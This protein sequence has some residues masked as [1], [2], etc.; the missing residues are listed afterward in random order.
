[1][2]NVSRARFP[3]R[4]WSLVEGEFM[5]F[6]YLIEPPFNYVDGTGRITGCDVELARYVFQHIGIDEVEFVETT[7]AQLLPGLAQGRWQM[8]TGLFASDERRQSAL[9]SDPIWALPDGLLV[10]RADVDRINGYRVVAKTDGLKIAVI[11]DQL[12]HQTALKHGIRANGIVVFETYAEAAGAVRDGRVDAYAS[13][14]Q[15]HDGF[16]R[17]TATSDLALVKI[18]TDEK[19]PALGCFA[20]ARTN[21]ELKNR[22]DAVLA[23]FIGGSG[24]R[25]LVKEFGFE[26]DDVDQLF[27]L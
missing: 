17:H 8:T 5:K 7:F 22:V 27:R 1:M 21:T 14:A 19:Q 16:L 13:V 4:F 6:A 15:A 24:H 26:G 20:F 3:V 9:F 2:S 18:P 11:R 10:R 12:Q 23:R 25:R